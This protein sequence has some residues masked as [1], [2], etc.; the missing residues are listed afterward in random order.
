M[1]RCWIALGYGG[2]GTTYA[3]IAAD[4][5]AGDR[6]PTRHFGRGRRSSQP[7]RKRS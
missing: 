6:R 5:I 7:N 4:I 3:A 2:N 1:P